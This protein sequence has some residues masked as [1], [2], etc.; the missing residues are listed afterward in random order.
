[1]KDSTTVRHYVFDFAEQILLPRLLRQR[2]QLHSATSLKFDINGVHRSN[3]GETYFFGL[4]EGHWPNEKA[5]NV[6]ISM[7]HHTMNRSAQS[8]G[9]TAGIL[10]SISDNCG[11]Q[12]ENKYFF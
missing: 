8:R 1:M 4:R 10:Y 2:G 6:F 3:A 5:A 9:R 12:N 11:G 7:L